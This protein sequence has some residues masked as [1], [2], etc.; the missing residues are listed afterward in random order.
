MPDK[1]SPLPEAQPHDLDNIKKINA[2]MSWLTNC[3]KRMTCENAAGMIPK[4]NTKDDNIRNTLNNYLWDKG[5]LATATHDEI[6]RLRGIIIDKAEE[7]EA[8]RIDQNFWEND[9][10]NR[11]FRQQTREQSRK[12]ESVS[13]FW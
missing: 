11:E 2:F 9:R 4:M 7:L 13:M 3:P 6:A 10:L 1:L 12:I 5:E 8:Q